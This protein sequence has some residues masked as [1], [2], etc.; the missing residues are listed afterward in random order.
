MPSVLIISFSYA[1]ASVRADVVAE[2][3]LAEVVDRAA[4]HV[5]QLDR[6]VGER[7]R[8]RFASCQLR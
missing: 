8:S 7:D 3:V 6:L 4:A 2:E 5:E 1:G